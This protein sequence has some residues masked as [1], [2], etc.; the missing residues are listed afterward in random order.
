[1]F[2]KELWFYPAVCVKTREKAAAAQLT[3]A[4]VAES[5]AAVKEKHTAAA[6]E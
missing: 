6:D 4:P 3:N 2:G 1:M 5:I